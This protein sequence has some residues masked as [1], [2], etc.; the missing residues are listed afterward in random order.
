MGTI[1][2]FDLSLR[3]SGIARL[4]S[5]ILATRTVKTNRK[6]CDLQDAVRKQ[7]HEAVH[8]LGPSVPDAVVM[9][10]GAYGAIRGQGY[11]ELAALRWLIKDHVR[12]V[13]NFDVVGIS[14]SHLK[15]SVTGNGRASK[16]EVM[17]AV[18]VECEKRF[19]PVPANDDEADAIGLILTYLADKAMDKT[20]KDLLGI[21]PL[22]QP[23]SMEPPDIAAGGAILPI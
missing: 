20:V 17:D 7:S 5:G 10:T 4:S 14:P 16:Q 3:S 9:E 11:E 18:L 19:W 21:E 13:Y 23:P 2:G 12:H 22:T 15:K 6:T 8:S 1:V